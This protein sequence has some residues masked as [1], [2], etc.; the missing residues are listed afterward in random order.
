MKEVTIT[1]GYIAF[2][3]D[4]D[5]EAVM[6]YKWQANIRVLPTGQKYVRALVKRYWKDMPIYMHH[7]VLNIEKGD[8]EGKTIDHI[9]RNPLNNQKENLRI[10]TRTE[11]MRNTLRHKE[12]KG[13]CFN[14]RAHL[15]C[16][17]LDEPVG[18][19]T[20]RK[21]LGYFHTEEAAKNA[22]QEARNA[23]I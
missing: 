12:H 20:K 1:K 19:A 22:V 11:N 17:Y 3:D 9:D 18:C 14:K 7:F 13:Y 5:F 2:V 21:Y 10:V 6:Q 15:W 4:E 16:A 23:R 8:L